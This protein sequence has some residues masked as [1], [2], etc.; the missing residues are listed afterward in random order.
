M[1]AQVAI[2]I[3][4]YNAHDTIKALFYSIASQSVV[5]ECKIILI[6]D[7]DKRSYDYLYEDFSSLDLVILRNEENLGPGLSRN[8]GIEKAIGLEIPYLIFADA[9]DQFYTTLS[10][11]M[12]LSTIINNGT[13][14]VCGSFCE[15][16]D[17][18][19]LTMEDYDIWLFSKI[20][21]TSI[22]KEF[23]IRFPKVGINEDVCFN[24]WYWLCSEN[25][26]VIKDSLYLWKNNPNSITR[27]NNNSYTWESFIPLCENLII[28][29]KN[30][31]NSGL[32]S[33]EKL[34]ASFANRL[35]RLYIGYN[36]FHDVADPNIPVSDM[37]KALQKFFQEV[38]KPYWDK[39]TDEDILSA[40]REINSKDS[41]DFIPSLGLR[42]FLKKIREE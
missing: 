8:K 19:L 6:D 26:T 16:L 12:L 34:I 4:A 42:E 22:I 23:N 3:P 18:S 20:Y 2:I 7:A 10:I 41:P 29:Y 25:K 11:E 15:E 21:R 9:D 36:N 33:E 37:L 13:D 30:I 14:L 31:I 17:N 1:N 38:I 28:T 5:D 32:V 35:V 40:W 39:I 24:L 27:R